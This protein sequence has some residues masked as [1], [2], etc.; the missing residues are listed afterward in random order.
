MA[1][2][3]AAPKQHPKLHLQSV[4]SPPKEEGSWPAPVFPASPEDCLKGKGLSPTDGVP[5]NHFREAEQMTA[6]SLSPT[7]RFQCLGE[8]EGLRL[9]EE[10]A[11]NRSNETNSAQQKGAGRVRGASAAQ[12][13]T[14]LDC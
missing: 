7:A 3:D 12:G 8:G 2:K 9:V 5:R 1:M 4:P 14:L 10:D 13:A 11:P 6:A